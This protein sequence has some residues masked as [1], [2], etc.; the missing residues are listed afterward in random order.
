MKE[1]SLINLVGNTPLL[2][3]KSKEWSDQVKVFAKLEG[4]N[5]GGSVK[6]RAAKSMILNALQRKDIQPGD[7]LVEATSGNT[8]IAL[9]MIASVLKLKMV[10]IMPSNATPER[11]KTM[12]AYGAE[13]ILTP[14]EKTIEFSRKHAQELAQKNNW[15]VLDQF[16]N[17][18]NKLAHYETTGPE[19]WSAT[20]GRVTHF[21][22]SM[23][24]TGTITGTSTYLKE[25]DPS[26]QIIGVQ[27]EEGSRIPGIRKWSTEMLPG[28]FEKDR[29]D[30]I[31]LVNRDSAIANAKSLALSYGIFAGMSSGG[32]FT[33]AKQVAAE[34]QSG[35]L[36]FIACDR[37]DRYL[38]SD[39]YE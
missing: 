25:Q 15:F 36:V 35:C 4:N 8:G 30:E 33:I 11:I 39:L 24:T 1:F 14:M 13:V 29:V 26:I 27:P 17:A 6:D 3:V 22:S 10:L 31:R 34:M 28:I 21:V 38:S 23:G 18:D 7:T 12:K 2:E 37:G 19:I 5:P 16:N 9:A 32:A 20:G